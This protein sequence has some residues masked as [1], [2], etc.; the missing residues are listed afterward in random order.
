M[1][2]AY[3]RNQKIKNKIRVKRNKFFKVSEKRKA[4]MKTKL[5]AKLR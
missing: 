2:N 4:K 5:T 3:I 1:F